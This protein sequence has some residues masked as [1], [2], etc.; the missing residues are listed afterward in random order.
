MPDGNLQD[1]LRDLLRTMRIDLRGM[2]AF[3]IKGRV[4]RVYGSEGAYLCDVQPLRCNEETREASSQNG[5][6]QVG[7]PIRQVPILTV[8]GGASRGLYALPAIGA[9]VRVSFFEGD[10]NW[11]AVD[12][13]LAPASP[14]VSGEDIAIYRDAS[15]RVLLQAD[16]TIRVTSASK[17]IVDAP[18]LEL[19][20]EGGAEVA[21][22]GD[23]VLVDGKTGQITGGSSAVRAK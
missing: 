5:S 18:R 3:P 2:Y 16:G 8:G 20:G 23:P 6:R 11:P 12:A 1:T 14:S 13:V 17:V 19:A 7:Q 9:V 15:T 21:R 22:K 10:Y 4:L